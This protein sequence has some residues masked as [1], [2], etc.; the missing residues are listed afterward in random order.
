MVLLILDTFPF[1]VLMPPRSNRLE[2][3]PY[4]LSVIGDAVLNSGR[5]LGI[6]RAADQP[7]VLQSTERRSQ[8]L[9][10]DIRHETPEFVEAARA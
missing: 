4:G 10:G 2:N 6:N 8:D 3:G 1:K 7:L 5:D 9:V